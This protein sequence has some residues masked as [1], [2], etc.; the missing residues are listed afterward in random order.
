MSKRPRR[1]LDWTLPAIVF[2]FALRPSWAQ[3]A[4]PIDFT[5]E[6]QPLLSD[7]CFHC[8]GPDEQT[9][10]ADLR[11][12]LKEGAFEDRGGYAAF[13]P[14]DLAKSEALA[15]MI[16]D[17]PDLRMPPADSGRTLGPKQIERVRRWIEQGAKW[18]EHWAFIV[19]E[20]PRVPRVNDR[21][22]SRG[23]IDTFV[24]ARLEREGLS[25]SP[26]ADR[27]T[28]LRRLSFDL[29]G[30]PPTPEEV[31]AFVNDRSPD[32]YARVVDRLLDSPHYGER[33]AMVWL[34]AARYADT[35]GFQ[36]DATRNNWAWRDWVVG[37][38]NRNMPFDQFTIEQFAGDLLPDATLEQR[39]ATCFHRNHMTNGE[40]GRDP[41]ESR[42][43]YV[44]DRT[45]TTGTVWL[46]LTLGCCQCH[47]HKY[48]P[49]TQTEYYQLTAFFNSIEETGKAA[50]AASPY[51]KYQSPWG[52][53]AVAN[54]TEAVN[55]RQ[56][57]LRRLDAKT[58]PAFDAWLTEELAAIKRGQ[59]TPVW[60]SVVAK[61]LTS[62]DGTKLAQDATGVITTSGPDPR[63]DDYL[64]TVSPDLPQL[65]GMRLEILPHASNTE[66]GLSRSDNGHFILT[67][68]KI[69]A[70]RKGS[71][72]IEEVPIVSAIADFSESVKGKA[73]G[74]VKDVLDDDPRTGWSSEGS[75][76]RTPRV[77]LFAFE[78][79][80]P[81]GDG[82]EYVIE[83]R[84]RSLSGPKNMGRFRLSLT[85]QF[86]PVVR[87]LEK[88]PLEELAS[89]DVPDVAS[90]PGRLKK[91]LHE[92]FL[93][94]RPEIV[95][96]RAALARAQSQL[97]EAK[98]W[99]GEVG[100]MVLEE[101]KEPRETHLLV[102]GVWDQKGEE[103]THG[104][105]AAV[106]PWKEA[107]STDR[108]A[109][110]RWLV[111]R[112]NPL[113][114]RVTVNRYWLMIFGAGL[115][116][117]PEDF[118]VQGERPTHPELLDWLAVEFVESGWNV[119]RLLKQIV[120][121]ATYRQRSEVTPERLESD[122]ENRLLG[123]SPRYRLPSWMI[124]DAALRAS[125]LL[126]ADL[127]GPPVRPYQP[128]GVWADRTM[129]RF[130]Y[131]PTD[132]AEQYRRSL[133]SFWRRSVA[134]TFMFDAAQRRVCQVRVTRTNTPLHALALLN[135]LTY[136]ES[137][138]A[139]AQDVMKNSFH[140]QRR[141]D[142]IARRVLSRSATGAER[143]RLGQLYQA[144]LAYYR[145]HPDDAHAYLRQGNWRPDESC[146]QAELAGLSLVASTLL[147]LDET[148]TRE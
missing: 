66:G 80:L 18:R 116:R 37:A 108:L 76:P 73:Y 45:N 147:N 133:Y 144:A 71:S 88:P 134:P 36:G 32:A 142:E 132:G 105:P 2:L 74:A 112:D 139:L 90:I 145:S 4:S 72:I 68:L 69:N 5:R 58:R 64:V 81:T 115:V 44:I 107:S 119:K 24:L 20:R 25:P 67:N 114:A 17:D 95:E 61:G 42:V 46:G 49:I 124:R 38:Y 59:A 60:R 135:D 100:V 26:E 54:A 77:A 110:A 15:R 92:Q 98:R 78:E 130:R 13:T 75:D 91:R 122:P 16:T 148:M 141:I 35:D 40:G 29:I 27:E 11:L 79:A 87:S 43:D 137:A 93:A 111:D 52:K 47:S 125:D 63:H 8:H 48:D 70:R 10:E 82:I 62:T 103:V 126:T 99:A 131:E 97:K 96:A 143:K 3:G 113:T 106:A 84:H 12:D 136:L 109:L 65:T 121:S 85:D 57:E 127:G 53:R 94:G 39:L 31:D 14:G 123:R 117:T 28:L 22:W 23:P 33:M 50:G 6:I 1:S 51:M 30:L 102:R 34:D 118:G 129:G 101:R 104:V 21:S 83:L 89:T 7:A 146:D 55:R 140:E 19:P 120:M 41:E 138:N 86:G 9:R 128:D 56:A